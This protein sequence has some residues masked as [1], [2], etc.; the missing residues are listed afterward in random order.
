MTV[1][2]RE[3]SPSRTAGSAVVWCDELAR[4]LARLE[5]KRLSHDC[6]AEAAGTARRC[7]TERELKNERRERETLLSSSPS[8]R[9]SASERLD[10]CPRRRSCSSRRRRT[11]A[12]RAST[13]PAATVSTM[14]MAKMGT[15]LEAEDADESS[16]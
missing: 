10:S 15:E 5:V 13:A 4:T 14:T 8:A 12:T 16:A 2:C 6:D 3:S 7:R 9:M 11:T 1:F